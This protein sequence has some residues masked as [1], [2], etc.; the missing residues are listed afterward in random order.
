METGKESLRTHTWKQL[1]LILHTSTHSSQELRILYRKQ[2]T[3][4]RQQTLWIAGNADGQPVCF[5]NRLGE[6]KHGRHTLVN[7]PWL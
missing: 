1:W 4:P 5:D 7:G 6:K 2:G 3:C